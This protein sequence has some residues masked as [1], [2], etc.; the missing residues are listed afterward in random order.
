MPDDTRLSRVN[1]FVS[2]AV[3]IAELAAWLLLEVRV[4]GLFRVATPLVPAERPGFSVALRPL[5]EI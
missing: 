4:G 5:D 2:R 1:Y 3:V